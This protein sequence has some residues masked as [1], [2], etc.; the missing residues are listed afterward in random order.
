MTEPADDDFNCAT[1]SANDLDCANVLQDAGLSRQELFPIREVARLTGVNPVTLRAWERRYGLIRPTRTASGH[2]LYSQTDIAAIRSILGWIERGV[3][4]SKVGKILHRTASAE[5]GV[6]IEQLDDREGLPAAQLAALAMS[7]ERSW[8]QQIKQA[9]AAFD[10]LWL[11][12]LYGQIFSNYPLAAVFQDV[13]MPVWQE[14]LTRQNDYGQ[15][16]EWLFFDA[17]LRGRAM[18]RLRMLETTAPAKIVLVAWPG[19][20]HELELLV[21]AILL[22]GPDFNVQVLAIGQPLTE[23]V[24][25]CERMQPQAVVVYSNLPCSPSVPRRLQTLSLALPCPVLLAGDVMHSAEEELLS[26]PIACL[27]SHGPTMR[28][29]LQRF[30]A[31]A[32]DT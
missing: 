2:R 3:A 1:Q 32:L 13:L 26:S 9:V 5:P 6:A 20:C 25:I 31:G 8:T 16:S 21:A 17:F 10:S 30:L 27:G 15:V 22:G 18:Q 29:R 24:L 12:R 7:F 11:Q 28:N 23:L 19:P 4:V 14:L